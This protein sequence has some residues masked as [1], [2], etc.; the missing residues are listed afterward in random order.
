MPWQIFTKFDKPVKERACEC[1]IFWIG[2]NGEFIKTTGSLNRERVREYEWSKE[3][4][5][6]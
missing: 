5:G 3:E 4:R 2:L 6:N 1:R